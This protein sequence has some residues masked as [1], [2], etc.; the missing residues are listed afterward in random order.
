MTCYLTDLE[1]N[2]TFYINISKQ[3]NSNS[4][5]LLNGEGLFLEEV[6]TLTAKLLFEMY[7]SVIHI[8]NI[9]DTK[10]T[11]MRVREF[12]WVCICVSWIYVVCNC[13]VP[14]PLYWME[15]C[16]KQ[17]LGIA[18]IE[19]QTCGCCNSETKKHHSW[20][21]SAAY[22]KL[23]TKWIKDFRHTFCSS[24]ASTQMIC[25]IHM[26][27]RLVWIH[28]VDRRNLAPPGMYKTL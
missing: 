12:G 21:I 7:M 8:Y 11:I 22:C 3:H 13:S 24:N 19:K 14:K 9:F 20:D 10:N 15:I 4:I 25:T 5:K 2:K 23:G 18:K 27:S 17:S 1:N 26:I 28:T 6:L 16:T